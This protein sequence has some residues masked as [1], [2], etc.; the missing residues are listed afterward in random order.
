MNGLF[1]RHIMSWSKMTPQIF[2]GKLFPFC[3]FLDPLTQDV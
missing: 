1:N 2:G 3:T